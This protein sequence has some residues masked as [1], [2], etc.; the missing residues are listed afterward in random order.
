MIGRASP[1]NGGI[2]L[3]GGEFLASPGMSSLGMLSMLLGPSE[4]GAGGMPVRARN[5]SCSCCCCL[6]EL[7][8]EACPPPSEIR[9]EKGRRG[10]TEREK[11]GGEREDDKGKREMMGLTQINHFVVP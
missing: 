6:G 4:G 3:A 2:P 11:E 7:F 10:E 1:A 5:G 8:A 9:R